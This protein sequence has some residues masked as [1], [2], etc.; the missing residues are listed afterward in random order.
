MDGRHLSLRK[1]LGLELYRRLHREA[2]ERHELRTLFWEC[3]LR[4]NLRCG[5]CG[6]D[7]TASPDSQ[8]M[9]A[10]D[11]FRV[12]DRQI[13]HRVD[14]HRVMVVLSGGEVLVRS[15]L[16]RIG[17]ALYDR[18]YPWGM[19]TNGMALTP[20]RF[21][22]LL[23]AG[24]HSMTVS[25]DGF[26]AEHNRLRRH[27]LSFA[28]AAEAVRMAAAE[29]SIAFD[30]VTCVTP[31]LVPRLD[32]FKEYLLSLGLRSWRLF[33]IF[34]AGRAAEDPA[35]QLSDGQFRALMEFVRRTRREGRIACSYACEGFLGGYEMEARDHFYHCDAGV[36]V[37]SIRVDGA[38]S[39]CTSV[40]ADYAQG[41]IYRDDFWQVWTERFEP[42]RR[43]EW[44]RRGACADCAAWRYCEGGPMHLRDADG[45]MMHCSYRRLCR[46]AAGWFRTGIAGG[47][48]TSVRAMKSAAAGKKWGG[49]AGSA[50]FVI[51]A[52]VMRKLF[53]RYALSAIVAP[54]LAVGCNDGIFID[55]FLP[56]APSVTVGPDDTSATIRFEAGNW[57]ILSVEGPTTSLR[58]DIYDAEGN[59]L[60]G[61]H[62]LYGDGLLRM[63]YDDGL[64]DFGIERN[65]YRTLR[66]TLGESLRDEPWETRIL[67]GNDYESETVSVT[68]AP[69]EKYRVDSVVYRWDEF[70]SWDNSIELQDAFTIDNTASSEPASVVVSPFRNAKRTVR[71]WPDD[72]NDR[73][74]E[75]FGVPLPEIV[76]P[77]MAD[78]TPVVAE[79]SAR[80]A[81]NDQQL[82]LSFP[83]DE[84]VTVTAKPH[85]RLNVE[86]YLSLEQ[87]RVP[88]TVYASG[89]AGRQRTFTGTLHSSLPYDY[90]ILKPKTDE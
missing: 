85:E 80:F 71:F 86:V 60:F 29:P 1:R 41:N 24:L 63:T 52:D 2:V 14:P 59:L 42:F 39:G 68:F 15:D 3:T 74:E 26:E 7:C 88:Y 76:I 62:P 30:A 57:D 58:G 55:D 73:R 66:I 54:L 8:D 89:P 34:P 78:G 51:F 9:P 37:A 82:P 43:R 40:R 38:I 61:N 11:F 32:E 18:E 35:L 84:Q 75:I 20:Q 72:F 87:F 36:S 44:M 28:R 12:L 64:L 13:T 83:D 79:S 69:T 21:D 27:P 65:D 56:E 46:S 16:E 48:E 47:C 33:A 77:D 17:R 70:E 19:V 53:S 4:C 22:G 31:A 81:R 49:V 90:L 67:V 25:I 5:H 45:G 23:G 50:F 6:S 10:E